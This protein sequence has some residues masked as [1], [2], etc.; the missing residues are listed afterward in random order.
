VFFNASSMSQAFAVL[1]RVVTGWGESSPLVTPLLVLVVAGTVAS[2][3][4]SPLRISRLQELFSQQRAMVQV[5]LLGFAL[6]GITTFG[7]V[8]VAPFIYYRF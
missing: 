6:L 4:V 1:D 3:F 5:G 8:G 2:Q 7:P